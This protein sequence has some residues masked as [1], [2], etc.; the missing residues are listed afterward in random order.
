[1]THTDHS[2]FMKNTEDIRNKVRDVAEEELEELGEVED[3]AMQRQVTMKA[4]LCK[5]KFLKIEIEALEKALEPAV[6]GEISLEQF[7]KI[8]EMFGE[9]SQKVRVDYPAVLEELE[10]AGAG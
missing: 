4:A 5:E 6:N 7:P 9:L 1:V 10:A 3:V 8:E 2:G